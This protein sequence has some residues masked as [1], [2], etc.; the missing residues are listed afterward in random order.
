MAESVSDTTTTATHALTSSSTHSATAR[1]SNPSTVTS[2]STTIL[3]AESTSSFILGPL[4]TTFTAPT[5]CS[6][7]YW[8]SASDRVY[9]PTIGQA[10]ASIS[11]EITYTQENDCLP[12]V[13]KSSIIGSLLGPSVITSTSYQY[14]GYYS[15][16]IAC[17]AGYTTACAVQGG[18]NGIQSALPSFQ[19]FSFIYSAL[20]NETAVGCCPQ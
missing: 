19:S 1:E 8:A 2:Y 10:C 13:N 20:A 6:Q 5:Q 9:D 18:T 4:T 16:G 17:P 14:T 15:P 3:S 7:A 12:P 11:G